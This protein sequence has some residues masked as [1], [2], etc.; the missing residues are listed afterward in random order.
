MNQ[1]E[2]DKKNEV[3]D[4]CVSTMNTRFSITK[5]SNT[6]NRIFWIWMSRHKWKLAKTMRKLILPI[7]EIYCVIIPLKLIG[8][9]SYHQNSIREAHTPS[10]GK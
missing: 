2:K 6:V 3:V 9:K 5:K 10:L 7:V 1:C 4:L 8:F